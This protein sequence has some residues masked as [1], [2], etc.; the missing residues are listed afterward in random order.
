MSS[1]SDLTGLYADHVVQ[2]PAPIQNLRC[3]CGHRR[4]HHIALGRECTCC[5]CLGFQAARIQ[6]AR[7]DDLKAGCFV[8]VKDPLDTAIWCEL[9]EAVEPRTESFLRFL[10]I[11][12]PVGRG[13]HMTRAGAELEYT[14]TDP[15]KATALAREFAIE[16]HGEQRYGD[17]PYAVHLDAVVAILRA[18]GLLPLAP[19]GYLHDVAEDCPQRV[20]ALRGLFP[21]EWPIVQAV[22]GEGENRRARVQSIYA[23]VAGNADAQNVK[24]ADRIANAEECIRTNGPQRAMYAREAAAFE[25]AMPLACESLRAALAAVHARL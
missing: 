21:D 3:T 6:C 25:A 5:K 12:R 15:E 24:V 14:A 20:E 8:R 2:S 11:K 17:Q 4:S 7:V 1:P 22:S 23:K 19:A 9:L 18:H 13:I 16:A 10:W